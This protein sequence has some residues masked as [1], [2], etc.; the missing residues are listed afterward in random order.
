[1]LY[2]FSHIFWR[3][4]LMS[5]QII[6][7]LFSR[8]AFVRRWILT[9]CRNLLD[10][11]RYEAEVAVPNGFRQPVKIY[12]STDLYRVPPLLYYLNSLI[13]RLIMLFDISFILKYEA[14]SFTHLDNFCI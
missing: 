8:H 5:N 12:W 13:I 11:R 10:T 7:R 6:I 3:A 9:G 4:I 14:H 2:F 1:M